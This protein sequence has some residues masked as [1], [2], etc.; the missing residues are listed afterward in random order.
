MME[1]HPMRDWHLFTTTTMPLSYFSTNNLLERRAWPDD[2]IRKCF[3]LPCVG[4]TTRHREKCCSVNERSS[5]RRRPGNNTAPL[6]RIGDR[7]S[8]PGGSRTSAPD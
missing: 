3:I 4:T 2:L 7:M 1:W 6:R 8:T 5:G